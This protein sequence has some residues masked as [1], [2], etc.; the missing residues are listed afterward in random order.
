MEVS[1]GTIIHF[2][3]IYAANKHPRIAVFLNRSL[4][5][6]I[7]EWQSDSRVVIS[8]EKYKEKS[9]TKQE[10]E[11]SL[12]KDATS[13]S[14]E[15][16]T[17]SKNRISSPDEQWMWSFENGFMQ[18]FM[19]AKAK[20]IDRATILRLIATKTDKKIDAQS[21][22][23][24]QAEMEALKGYADIFVEILVSRAPSSLYG[25]ELKATAKEVNTGRIIA[26]VTSLRWKESDLRKRRV[27]ATEKGYKVVEQKLLP[28]L[29]DIASNL[30]I[31][32]MNAL[33]QTWN[34]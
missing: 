19:Q 28:P 18:P 6:E 3:R 32:L 22:S 4:S 11:S 34:E 15:K 10:K 21:I 12:K 26:N 9:N 13:V 14:I 25:Y 31:E 2:E 24:K 7:R 33:I 20:L 1:K 8:E 5:D 16:S 29:E 27:I 17:D 23:V 30:A